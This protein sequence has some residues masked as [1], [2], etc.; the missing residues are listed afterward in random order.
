MG[1][2]RHHTGFVHPIGLPRRLTFLAEAL[3]FERDCDMSV[4]RKR[5]HIDILVKLTNVK[6]VFSIAALASARFDLPPSAY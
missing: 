6:V 1:A 4:F 2:V 3:A 5:L